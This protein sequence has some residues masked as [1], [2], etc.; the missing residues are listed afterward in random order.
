MI[1]K[2]SLL[3]HLLV[4]LC[5]KNLSGSN[6]INYSKLYFEHLTVEEGLPSVAITD[7]L[8][9][10]DGFL[11]FASQNGLIMY[12]SHRFYS[13]QNSIG[14]STSLSN[15]SVKCLANN[16]DGDI[17]VG[18]DYGLNRLDKNTGEFKRFYKIED[19][20]NSLFNS[21]INDLFRDEKGVI[22]IAS[23]GGLCYISKGDKKIRRVHVDESLV[24]NRI[25]MPLKLAYDFAFTCIAS[26]KQGGL[27]LGTFGYG[28]FHYN[29]TTGSTKKFFFK[30][31][32]DY[33]IIKKIV[34]DD[35]GNVHFGSPRCPHIVF[36]P[37]KEKI[38]RIYEKENV[39][40][41][42]IDNLNSIWSGYDR[43]L[44]VME[45]NGEG[46]I[47]SYVPS[48]SNPNSISEGIINVIYQ[49]RAGSVWLSSLGKGLDVYHPYKN[50]FLND[51]IDFKNE[52]YTDYGKTILVDSRGNVWY[53]TFGNGILL[54][55]E[56]FNIKRRFLK[57]EGRV[58]SLSGNYIYCLMEDA[59]KNIWIGTDKG[60]SIYSLVEKRFIRRI[61]KIK[62]DNNSLTH[63]VIYDIFHDSQGISWIATQEGLDYIDAKN[64]K[65]RHLKE[66]DGLCYYKVTCITEDLNHNL[67][68]GSF[69]GLSKYSPETGVFECYH[70]KKKEPYQISNQHILG[71]HVDKKGNVWV[72]T[73][74]GLNRIDA[75]SG[76]VNVYLKETGG[77]D[78]KVKNVSSDDLG[79]IWAHHGTGVSMLNP[80]SNRII[81]YDRKNNLKV[82][83]SGFYLKDS[84]M[85]VGGENTGMYKININRLKNND[86]QAPIYLSKIK[87][88]GK[89]LRFKDKGIGVQQDVTTKHVFSHHE[90]SYE[91]SF[92]TPD[93]VSPDAITYKY[94]LEGVDEEWKTALSTERQA[95]YNNLGSGDYTFM[96]RALKNNVAQ[97]SH[98]AAFKFYIRPPWW[99][100]LWA[101][102]MFLVVFSGLL[103]LILKIRNGR[104]ELLLKMQ[105]AREQMKLQQEAENLKLKYFTDISHEFRTPLTLISVPIE[106]LYEDKQLSEGQKEKLRLAKKNIARLQKLINQFLDYR[107]ISNK[108]M[109]VKESTTEIV[110]FMQSICDLFYP[111]CSKKNVKLDFKTNKQEFYCTIDSGK[112]DTIIYN[113]LYNAYKHTPKEGG[114]YIDLQINPNFKERHNKH[115]LEINIANTG[116]GI[117][118]KYLD[119]IFNRFYQ[120]PGSELGVESGTGIG[121]SLV[122]EY[123]D[124][125]GGS[126]QVLSKIGQQ[127]I[128]KVWI[129]VQFAIDNETKN[130][131]SSLTMHSDIQLENELETSAGYIEND[132]EPLVDSNKKQCL[133]VEDNKELRKVLH[134][135]LSSQY[136][137]FEAEN[138]KTG[139]EKAVQLIPDIIISDIMMPEMDGF[140]L[141]EKCKNHEFIAH[142]PIVLLTARTEDWSKIKGFSTGADA[143]IGKPFDIKVLKSQIANLL[144]NRQRL[145]KKFSGVS[146][147]SGNLP[148]NSVDTSF[149]LKVNKVIDKHVSSESLS[150]NFIAE[151]L[152]MSVRQLH[153]KFNGL[154]DAGPGEYIR[155][156]KLKKAAHVLACDKNITISELAFNVGFKHATN[157]ASAFKK[158]FGVSPTEFQ[159]K[160]GL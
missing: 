45:K 12:D 148:S 20:T 139:F 44:A 59:D 42:D 95:S 119:K 32:P 2:I 61:N 41:L 113:L 26:D 126:I 115:S 43:G 16:D 60:I 63:D 24:D 82:N 53:G 155:E 117:E 33:N 8:Q 90:S 73:R 85:L 23:K 110:G 140:E 134:E 128:F 158:Q 99:R 39:Y 150:V 4:L 78:S 65:L 81:Y 22:W 50:N 137:V 86:Y 47:H 27:W 70:P 9:D 142:V 79:R 130:E 143:Y 108:K 52:Q 93:Y 125:L 96:V 146:F 10:N 106:T 21:K 103:A 124:L 136:Q 3:L 18:T 105:L 46:K 154:L 147:S 131:V 98:M 72:G 122:K 29:P 123:I 13:F 156:Y 138:G 5:P 114:I 121:L 104:K 34:V 92:V 129:P 1:R 17:W 68:F 30:E 38:A 135:L 153:R 28:L 132:A 145:M 120:I 118:D 71:L 151:E 160:E 7:I 62:G 94:K 107:K 159:E 15:N 11:W 127:T 37:K 40:S 35:S 6:S 19:D 80:V 102:I 49:D 152:G 77:F 141:C 157:F 56:Q 74:D 91:F 58:R 133:I 57:D 100:T 112:L 51:Y 31:N 75:T 83:N 88:N 76:R 66:K 14:D 111:Y 67:W 109:E 89:A 69:N 84:I 149:L 25:A 54:L 87:V 48:K 36:S 97:S 55:G 101:M 64:G 116:K 144:N